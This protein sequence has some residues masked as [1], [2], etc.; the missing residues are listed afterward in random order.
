MVGHVRL[1]DA[2]GSLCVSGGP[3][4]GAP[5]DISQVEP[6]RQPTLLDN[7]YSRDSSPPGRRCW[8]WRFRRAHQALD[9]AV[10]RLNR[11]TGF[12][13]ERERAEHLFMLYEKM[14]APFGIGV[15]KPKRRR[16]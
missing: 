2:Q 16:R 3:R 13:S 7:Y 15:K 10:D 9:R 14:R 6:L 1:P 12:A 4:L 11:Q 8:Y 5:N